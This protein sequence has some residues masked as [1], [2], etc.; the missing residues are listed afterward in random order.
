MTVE[1]IDA[2][3]CVNGHPVLRAPFRLQW[4]AAQSAW[5]LLYPEGMVKLSPS[6]GEIMR[7]C[8]GELTVDALISELE[9]QFNAA[10]IREDVLGFLQVASKQGWVYLTTSE[11][12]T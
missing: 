7:R 5:V 1:Q 6:A 2:G 9:A 3:I 10:G 11:R 12:S 8:N 4:E